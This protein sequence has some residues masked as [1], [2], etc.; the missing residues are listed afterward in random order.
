MK[1]K[2]QRKLTKKFLSMFAASA[3]MIS[4]ITVCLS[5]GAVDDAELSDTLSAQ[6]M[7]SKTFEEA[8]LPKLT[9]AEKRA[10]AFDEQND[11]AIPFETIHIVGNSGEERPLYPF[12]QYPADDMF[13]DDIYEPEPIDSYEVILKDGLYYKVYEDHAQVAYC[14]TEDPVIKSEING[15]PVTS[16]FRYAF[17][18][19]KIKSVYIP[20]TVT[21]IQSSAFGGTELAS[22]DIPD[23]VT[24]IGVFAF[25]NMKNL[26][27]ITL[28]P[29]LIVLSRGTFMGC[30]SLSEINLPA[31]LKTIGQAAFCKC[32]SLEHLDLPEGLEFIDIAAFADCGLTELKIPA[33]IEYISMSLENSNITSLIYDD[34]MTEFPKSYRDYTDKLESITLPANLTSI[35]DGAFSECYLLSS[36]KL[37]ENLRSIGQFA[38]YE[39]GVETLDLPDS[40]ESIGNDCFS[41]SKLKSIVIPNNITNIQSSTFYQCK[42]LQNVTLPENLRSIG[43]FAFYESGIETL[44]LPDSLEFIE[45][46]CFDSSNIKNITIPDSVKYIGGSCFENTN[47]KSISIPD[48]ITS[49]EDNT[50]LFCRSLEEIRLP[51]HLKKISSSAFESCSSL[52]NIDLPDE[53]ET[54]GNNAFAYTIFKSIHIPASVTSIESS[55]FYG[56]K[57]RTIYGEKGSYAERFAAENNYKFKDINDPITDEEED[58]EEKDDDVDDIEDDIEEDY[59]EGGWYD[60]TSLPTSGTYKLKCNVTIDKPIEIESDLKLDL[61][62]H[63]VNADCFCVYGNMTVTDSSKDKKGCVSTSGY[64]LFAVGGTLKLSGGTFIENLTIDEGLDP[65]VTIIIFGNGKFILDGA[66][67]ISRNGTPLMVFPVFFSYENYSADID[68]RS[69]TLESTCKY[70]SKEPYW[71]SAAMLAYTENDDIF[72]LKNA[73][74]KS[75]VGYGIYTHTPDINLNISGGRIESKNEYGIYSEY[76][77]KA[78]L[79]GNPEIIGGK[80]GICVHDSGKINISGR[81]TGGN[82]TIDSEDEAVFTNGYSKYNKGIAPSLFFTP[83]NG[84][85]IYVDETGELAYN[86]KIADDQEICK[87]AVK[88]Y[89]KRTNEAVVGYDITSV[90]DTEYEI[91]LKDY[92]GDV[93]DVYNIDSSSGKG[94]NS[95]D[96]AIDL[97]QT[98]NNSVTVWLALLGSLILIVIGIISMKYSF[99]IRRR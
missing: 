57:L 3:V 63:K 75:E 16:I 65:V 37:P 47:I 31:S 27:S 72:H 85:R 60:P 21:Q 82:I 23:S 5:A 8:P 58:E 66:K 95:A 62:G 71:Y 67:V 52:A 1:T 69:G 54:I 86:R 76:G 50:F 84:G 28:P 24:E 83:A 53:L 73:T 80:G 81:L 77:T 30:T 70:K 41:K 18:N 39:S 51:A 26:K 99:I 34:S 97:P 98:G 36:V 49:I 79:S 55:A 46:W 13:D 94:T 12:E 20:D 96:Q 45:D 56:S 4:Q 6:N 87:W 35:P 38:F 88:D 25:G 40:L 92:N 48:K 90:S 9:E 74:L 22:I 2:H 17:Q 32:Y 89:E 11:I 64:F 29:K 78:F 33:S 14:E 15:K 68:L 61:N 44:E 42:F 59:E 93:L 19:K 7:V 43:Q 91:I 10:D